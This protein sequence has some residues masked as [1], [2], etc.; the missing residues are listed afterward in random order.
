MPTRAEVYWFDLTGKNKKEGW[1]GVKLLDEGSQNNDGGALQ[2]QGVFEH[3]AI[4]EG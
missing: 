4:E 1:P 2:W 3:P